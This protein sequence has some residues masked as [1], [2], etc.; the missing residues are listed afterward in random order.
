MAALNSLPIDWLAISPYSTK[1][2]LGGISKASEPA[3]ATDPPAS[4]GS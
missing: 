3:A 1:P 4:P 2:T